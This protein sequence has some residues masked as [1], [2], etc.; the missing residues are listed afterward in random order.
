MPEMYAE[1]ESGYQFSKTERG[2]RG[3]REFIRDDVDGTIAAASL[4]TIGTST[5]VDE[6]GSSVSDCICRTMDPSWEDGVKKYVA[7]YDTNSTSASG[8]TSVPTDTASRSFS[9]AAEAVSI[10]STP[11]N[12]WRWEG[13]TEPVS[14][15]VFK[16]IFTGEF[17]IPKS[18]MTSA[19]KATWLAEV[20]SNAHCINDD[21]FEG[22]AEG[23]V[24]FVG[25]DGGTSRES[26]GDLVWSFNMIFRFR[27]IKDPLSSF[28]QDDWLYLWDKDQG[29][30]DKPEWYNGVSYVN[31]Y[32]KSDLT[33][34][35]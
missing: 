17:T 27:I 22:F 20:V 29:K 26:N 33:D 14:Q 28:T 3:R 7:T 32:T 31:L 25:I 12:G 5:M 35:L 23:R 30:W 6:S 34:L 8:S 16:N 10:E 18:G 19:E 1:R 15:Q 9:G 24:L 13:S 4:P 11:G 21:T 2:A